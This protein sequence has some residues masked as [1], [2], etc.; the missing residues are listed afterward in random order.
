MLDANNPPIALVLT[1]LVVLLTGCVHIPGERL[2]P[3][4][5]AGELSGHVRFL[6][7]PAPSLLRTSAPPPKRD[8]A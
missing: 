1:V 3:A 2:S 7:Q 4:I 8:T 6:A 5:E